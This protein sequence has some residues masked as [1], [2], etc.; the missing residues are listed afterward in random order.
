LESFK[1]HLTFH[2]GI[3]IAAVFPAVVLL[4]STGSTAVALLLVAFLN[5]LGLT[6][7]HWLVVVSFHVLKPMAGILGMD[8]VAPERM[9]IRLSSLKTLKSLKGGIPPD[10]ILLLLPHCLQNH[11]C[12]HR[13]TFDPTNCRECGGCPVGDL[14]ALAER[15]GI[16]VSVATG[17]TLARRHVKE[18]D[19][20]A[21]IAVACPR[22]LGQGMLDAYPVPVIGIENSRPFG[23]CLD[24]RVDIAAVEKAVTDLT[25]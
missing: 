7:V 23:D 21:V 5:I 15:K 9:V 11:L 10:R 4:L 2:L 3:T 19:P 24:T 25:S 22:D 16:K 12:T 20:L 14:M 17:G 6:R 13:I 18:H 8:G 1:D